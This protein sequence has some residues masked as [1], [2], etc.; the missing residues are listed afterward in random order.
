MDIIVN[1]FFAM[2]EILPIYLIASLG[3]FLSQRVGVYDISIEGNMTVAS[4]L[5]LI[6]YHMSGSPWV[7]LLLA[8]A[9]GAIFGIIL[10]TFTVDFNL[11]NIIT[12]F[13]LWYMGM[14]M[15]SF[16]YKLF[17]PSN[18]TTEKFRSLAELIGFQAAE[19]TAVT[20]LLDL[21][22]IFYLS[23]V[24]VVIIWFI[25]YKTKWGILMRAIGENPAVVD[26]AGSNIF[27]IKR[28]S[29]VIGTSLVAIAG[30]YLAID[31][32]QGFTQGMVA[33]RGWIAFSIIIFA[34]WKPINIMYGCLIFAGINGLQLRLQTIGINIHSALLTATPYIATIVVLSLIMTR[35]GGA[36][37]PS[38]LGKPYHR[39]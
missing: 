16:L 18:Q 24:L 11:N 9:G 23:L 30:A 19:E 20:R 12:G 33:G 13:G 34:R 38:A 14:G 2:L 26:A 8:I 32:L 10:S 28:I 3:G 35:A 36:R 29:I 15:A 1:S 31:F 4:V 7:G 6:G 17:V 22:I 25:I 27:R 21:D 37:M 5:G 39:E